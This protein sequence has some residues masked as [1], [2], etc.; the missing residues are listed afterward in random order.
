MI[1][2]DAKTIPHAE[3]RYPTVGDWSVAPDGTR[4]FSVSDMGN[5]DFE[6]LVLIHEMIEQHLCEKRGISADR[7]DEFDTIYEK[8]RPD[9]D[10]SEPGDD[11]LAPYYR[12]HQM[13]TA[14][15]RLLAVELQVDWNEYNDKVNSL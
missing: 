14:I 8:T 12:E 7:V 13:A 10:T 4:T 11:P 15:E 6:F 5:K 9:G 3:Q 1:K 2:V